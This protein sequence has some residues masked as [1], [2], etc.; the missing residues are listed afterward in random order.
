MPNTRMVVSFD[1][2]A[3]GVTDV[4]IPSQILDIRSA[5][6]CT[7]QLKIAIVL[8]ETMLVS[9]M[10]IFAPIAMN[11]MNV[12]IYTDEQIAQMYDVIRTNKLQAWLKVEANYR[13]TPVKDWTI[14][15][16]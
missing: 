7:E 16:F 15:S 3:A 6:D 5:K 14:H 9:A 11:G 2:F 4:L 8:P 13:D 12:C 10:K 1:T